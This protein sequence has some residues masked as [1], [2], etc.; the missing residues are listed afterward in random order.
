V[1]YSPA[2]MRAADSGDGIGQLE[3]VAASEVAKAQ[4]KS[5]ASGHR[6]VI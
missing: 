2:C 1:I 4:V 6:I 3:T 5:V